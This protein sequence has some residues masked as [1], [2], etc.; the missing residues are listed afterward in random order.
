MSADGRLVNDCGGCERKRG[1]LLCD[2]CAT[3][4]YALLAFDKVLAGD[5]RAAVE[6]YRAARAHEEAAQ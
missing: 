6:A 1:E 5:Q 4:F 2:N 3:T